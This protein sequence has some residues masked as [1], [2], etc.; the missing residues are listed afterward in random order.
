MLWGSPQTRAERKTPTLSGQALLLSA[1]QGSGTP[2][3]TESAGA[4]GGLGGLLRGDPAQQSQSRPS[5]SP[6]QAQPGHSPPPR[7]RRAPSLEWRVLKTPPVWAWPRTPSLH[8]R[9]QPA[10]GVVMSREDPH[11]CGRGQ[12]TPRPPLKGVARGHQHCRGVL[13]R[14]VAYPSPSPSPVNHSLES[15]SAGRGEKGGGKGVGRSRGS[16]TPAPCPLLETQ[17]LPETGGG[18]KK[19]AGLLEPPRGDL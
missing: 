2:F 9:V 13:L 8:G 6:S 17:E 14:G 15:G 18:E 16:F 7:P 10:R 4:A 12:K 5:P 3:P 1:S 19:N 11:F